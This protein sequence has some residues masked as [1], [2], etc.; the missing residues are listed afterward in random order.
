MFSTANLAGDPVAVSGVKEILS[1]TVLAL[2]ALA[3]AYLLLDNVQNRRAPHPFA[4]SPIAFDE[5]LQLH[6]DI[7]G[8]YWLL[9]QARLDS[10]GSHAWDH[11]EA[12]LPL[13]NGY[14][15]DYL[16]LIY[17]WMIG[18]YFRGNLSLDERPSDADPTLVLTFL[19]DQGIDHDAEASFFRLLQKLTRSEA[20]TLTDF[21]AVRA[22]KSK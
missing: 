5:E 1:M 3:N 4:D 21:T 16:N 19:S 10:I 8:D 14:A 20:T 7:L 13:H 17:A 12:A 18:W 6:P 11:L 15:E 2:G 9:R 22:L